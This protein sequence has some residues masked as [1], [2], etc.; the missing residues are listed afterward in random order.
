MH[1]G[2]FIIVILLTPV[3][4]S[5]VIIGVNECQGLSPFEQGGLAA[6]SKR[7]QIADSVRMYSKRERLK[8]ATF[9]DINP[10]QIVDSSNVS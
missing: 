8:C 4:P 1:R 6:M 9:T 10:A 3:R 7:E 2:Q 5:D